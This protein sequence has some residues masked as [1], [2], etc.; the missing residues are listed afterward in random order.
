VIRGSSTIG[1]RPFAN[2]ATIQR[3]GT[4]LRYALDRSSYGNIVALTHEVGHYL[5]TILQLVDAPDIKKSFDANNKWDV[6]EIATNRHLGG[7]KELSQ[8][9]KLA[10]TGRRILQWV[11][12]NDFET[13]IDPGVF[14]AEARTMAPYAESW[15]AAY[16]MTGEGRRFPGVTSQLRWSVGLPDKRNGRAAARA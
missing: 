4:D 8:R 9:A 6:V 7:A 14:Q 2:I 11:A 5:K 15:I 13:T 16:R 3:L 12:D 10:E 1:Q